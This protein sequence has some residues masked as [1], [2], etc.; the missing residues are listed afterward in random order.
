MGFIRAEGGDYFFTRANLL[1]EQ[2]RIQLKPGMTV[3]FV[4]IKLPSEWGDFRRSER[5]SLERWK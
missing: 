3:K 2:R 4:R 5:Q 1:S